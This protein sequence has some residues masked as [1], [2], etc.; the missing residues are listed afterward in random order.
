MA[1]PRA[2]AWVERL[3]WILIYGGVIALTLGVATGG[4]HR[5]AS[6]SLGVIGGLAVAAGVVLVVVRSR[7]S[8]GPPGGAQSSNETPTKETR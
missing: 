2:L 1:S 5:A 4:R 8:E 6:W 7:L 3:V